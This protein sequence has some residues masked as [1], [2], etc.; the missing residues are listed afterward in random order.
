MLHTTHVN[1]KMAG[2]R[3]GLQTLI[4]NPIVLV[5]PHQ[6]GDLSPG[7]PLEGH[8][9]SGTRSSIKLDFYKLS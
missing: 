4:S 6:I 8:L 1:L 7:S 5:P 2:N 9:G 3:L